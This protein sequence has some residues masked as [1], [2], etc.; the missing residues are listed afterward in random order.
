MC[1]YKQMKDSTKTASTRK[2]EPKHPLVMMHVS[3]S[4]SYLAE[5][6]QLLPT[7]EKKCRL[8]TSNL[9]LGEAAAKRRPEVCNSGPKVM[10]K[11]SQVTKTWIFPPQ[12][13]S[14]LES[15]IIKLLRRRARG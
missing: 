2:T 12:S 11:H 7:G 10:R 9:H 1:L 15:D 8:Q 5:V 3:M 13:Q 6:T 4:S 14:R